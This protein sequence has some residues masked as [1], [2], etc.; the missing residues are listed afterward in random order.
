[1]AHVQHLHDHPP[2]GRHLVLPPDLAGRTHPEGEGVTEI[3]VEGL[4]EE[5]LQIEGISH[6]LAL[7]EEVEVLG[8]AG[9]QAEPQLQAEPSLQHP[10]VVQ[11]EARED[12]LEGEA[13]PHALDGA[14]LG[15]RHVAEP[16][17]QAGG[18]RVSHVHSSG[19]VP[20]PGGGP[21][22]RARRRS[23]GAVGGGW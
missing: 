18:A 15:R 8:G 17:G 9:L 11:G 19:A 5:V 16:F 1:M 10:A 23:G 6:V 4:V 7:P 20:V 13:V 12:A 22:A 2:R 21:A 3:G 14:A